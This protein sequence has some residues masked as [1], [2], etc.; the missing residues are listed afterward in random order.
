MSDKFEI[1]IKAQQRQGDKLNDKLKWPNHTIGHLIGA[2]MSIHNPADAKEFQESYLA[3]VKEHP[4]DSR[5]TPEQIVSA[6]IGWCFGEGMDP[7][8]IAM[9]VALGNAHPIFG[10]VLP[11]PE[12]AVQMGLE[13]GQGK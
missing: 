5:Y 10:T 8:D 4:A 1:S 2:I 6:N 7:S 3:W 12:K 11:T 13:A 9:W